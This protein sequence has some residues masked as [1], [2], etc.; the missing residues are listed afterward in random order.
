M[1]TEFLYKRIGKIVTLFI[2]F[3]FLCFSFVYA[4]FLSSA[5]IVDTARTFYF[6]VSPSTH[7]QV[8]A[9]NAAQI[10][11]AGYLI[12]ASGRDYVAFS[13]YLTDTAAS[14]V[15]NNLTD[16]PTHIIP[17]ESNKLYLKTR[18]QKGKESV[19][20]NAFSCLMDCI[21]I[22]DM[23]IARVEGGATQQSSKRILKSM[24]NTF[25]FLSK[26]YQNRFA[27]F[28][29]VCRDAANTLSTFTKSTVY[30]ADLRYLQCAL[31]ISY[32]N[33]SEDFCL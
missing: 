24:E 17:L 25:A 9:H 5:T 13:V 6:L 11:G 33:L 20:K 4:A 12:H 30:I 31:C 1:T 28:A 3:A 8:S 32:L 26:E 10:G 19:Y 27:A 16:T 15:S 22:L 21:R 2:T 23:E 7:L 29:T 14:S 18:R